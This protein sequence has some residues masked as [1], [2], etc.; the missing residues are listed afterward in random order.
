MVRNAVVGGLV[1]LCVDAITGASQDL[2]PNPYAG[3]CKQKEARPAIRINSAIVRPGGAKNYYRKK[4][5]DD[6]VV[7]IANGYS[8][9]SVIGW[10]KSRI[11][12]LPGAKS[13]CTKL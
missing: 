3:C 2:Y 1:G 13:G 10:Q 6:D 12:G 4:P 9:A 11:I 8:Q 5:L 7:L